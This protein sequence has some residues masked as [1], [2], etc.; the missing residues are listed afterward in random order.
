MEREKILEIN[1]MKISFTQ[2]QKGI[3]QTELPVIKDLNHLKMSESMSLLM[4]YLIMISMICI[5][6]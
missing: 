1:N 3:Q 4:N 5:G 2:Y 6:S